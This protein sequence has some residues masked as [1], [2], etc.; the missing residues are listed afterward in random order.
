MMERR[1]WDKATER[2]Q[3]IRGKMGAY[4]KEINYLKTAK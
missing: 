1:K 2:K 4:H 3:R